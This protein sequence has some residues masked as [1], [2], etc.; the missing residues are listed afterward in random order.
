MLPEEFRGHL[1]YGAY[2]AVP[3]EALSGGGRQALGTRHPMLR[4]FC[5]LIGSRRQAVLPGP[6][7]EEVLMGTK[8]VAR[9]RAVKAAAPSK[10][11]KGHSQDARA[12]GEDSR[13]ISGPRQTLS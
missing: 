7:D 4:S 9:V 13:F 2:G 6:G 8:R 3:V 10:P 11:T 1:Y 12:S 5:E